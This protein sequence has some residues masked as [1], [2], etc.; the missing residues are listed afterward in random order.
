M[1]DYY[2]DIINTQCKLRESSKV[3]HFYPTNGAVH[4]FIQSL[5]F[6]PAS[7]FNILFLKKIWPA[8]AEQLKHNVEGS[9]VHI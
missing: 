8:N 5:M 4:S 1:G 3:R 6:S 9:A 7:Y 2:V